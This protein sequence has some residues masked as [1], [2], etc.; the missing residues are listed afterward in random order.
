MKTY[1]VVV[2]GA[3]IAGL[4][5]AYQLHLRNVSVQLLEADPRRVGGK[6][7][8]VMAP[9]HPYVH[10]MSALVTMPNSH[11]LETLMQE[12]LDEKV[13]PTRGACEATLAMEGQT[14]KQWI[15]DRQHID[16]SWEFYTGYWQAFRKYIEYHRRW[17]G[18][19]SLVYDYAHM[20]RHRQVL[21]QSLATFLRRH[22][23]TI[24]QG[25][26]EIALSGYG[27]GNDF[28]E[29]PLVYAMLYVHAEAVEALV[30]R[31]WRP[32]SN[33][34]PSGF[35]AL[36]QSLWKRLRKHRIGR[37][38]M[39]VTRVQTGPDGVW[40]IRTASQR[41]VSTRQIVW[42]CNQ[43]Q[44]QKLTPVVQ[45]RRLLHTQV[46]HFVSAILVVGAKNLSSNVQ[47]IS[48]T[49]DGVFGTFRNDLCSEEDSK[50]ASVTVFQGASTKLPK[51]LLRRTMRE[52]VVGGHIKSER[53]WDSMF[54]HWT[55]GDTYFQLQELQGV[56]QQWYVGG[57]ATFECVEAILKH[58]QYVVDEIVDSL[59][60]DTSSLA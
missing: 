19:S 45:V 1:D 38:N 2:I 17:M 59:A 14:S 4:N 26:F 44:V 31:F 32:G 23:L 33:M 49:K 29:I 40:Q 7:V 9:R 15:M 11:N 25:F 18:P 58:S 43:K 46:S 6:I 36:T 27:Y 54:P 21:S 22:E 56:D 55:R 60:T 39:K 24:L 35:A 16:N 51:T 52:N 41:T 47:D 48:V 28:R 5:T 50:Q 57:Y 10:H 34:V 8:D 53:Q 30:Y 12:V 20:K 13:V 42:A 3:G 37:L